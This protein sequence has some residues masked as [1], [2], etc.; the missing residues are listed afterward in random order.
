[1]LDG[2]K[3]L[4]EKENIAEGLSGSFM[5]SLDPGR[6]TLLLPRWRGRARHPDDRRGGAGPGLA[7]AKPRRSPSTGSTSRTTPPNSRPPRPPSSPRSRPAKPRRRGRCT[8][9]PGGPT[10]GSS[11][12]PSPSATSTR[13]STPVR[14]TSGPGEFRRLPPDREGALGGRTTAAYPSPGNWKPTS[15]ELRAQGEDGRPE[16]RR[17]SPTASTSCSARSRPR[18]SPAR[19]SATRTPTWST[20]SPTRRAPKRPS[21]RSSRC[22]PSRTRSWRGKSKRA[23]KT[24]SSALK[25]YRRGDGF[26]PYTELSKADTRKLAQKIDALAEQLSQVPAQIV[27]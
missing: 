2:E 25:P 17:R 1:M 18:R 22:S 8:R 15:K 27:G 10:S 14:T 7:K 3:I 19:R 6:Y 12:W 5:L 21:R 20:S 26:V 13:A 11:R 23:S 9:R 24:F 4:G 16:K